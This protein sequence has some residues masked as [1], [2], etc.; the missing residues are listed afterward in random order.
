MTVLS[1][2]EFSLSSPILYCQDQ[3]P[4][5]FV[6]VSALRASSARRHDYHLSAEFEVCR[7]IHIYRTQPF[8]VFKLLFQ[9][10]LFALL[11]WF[12]AL[13]QLGTVVMATFEYLEELMAHCNVFPQ[14]IYDV[15]GI[16]RW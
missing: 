3:Y 1:P 2:P 9:K 14:E 12:R 13:H 4:L 5:S 8:G 11:G 6:S 7:H 15:G 16:V 10:Y